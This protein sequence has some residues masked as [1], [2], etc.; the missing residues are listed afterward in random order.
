MVEAITELIKALGVDLTVSVHG[1]PMAVPHTRPLGVTAHA[2]DPRLIAGNEPGVRHASR[3]RR[4]GRPARAA[5][6][7]GRPRRLGF[8]VHVPHYLGQ[9]EFADAALRGLDAVVRRDRAQPAQDDLR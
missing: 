9:A 1:I 2:T 7:R 5:A 8:A 3:C 6:R 4:A